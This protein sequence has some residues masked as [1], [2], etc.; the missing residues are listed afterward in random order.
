VLFRSVLP[1]LAAGLVWNT[2]RFN[3]SGTLSVAAYAPP[4]ITRS[5]VTGGNFEVTGSGGIPYWT[6]YVLAATNVSLPS[7][8]WIPLATNQFD[9]NGNFA[10]TNTIN[11]TCP[12]LFLKVQLQ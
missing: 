7:A 2:N 10:F 1:P 3:L 5:V 11:S 4:A 8:Q 6:Y 9:A 12:Q